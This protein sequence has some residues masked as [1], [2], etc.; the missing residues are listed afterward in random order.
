M[1]PTQ[2]R[3]II[4]ISALSYA[5]DNDRFSEV[6][7]RAQ[8]L[9]IGQPDHA[10]NWRLLGAALLKLGEAT[11]AV[12]ALNR[13]LQVDRLD[14]PT[15]GIRGVALQGLGFITAG[16]QSYA[17]ALVIDPQDADDLQAFFRPRVIG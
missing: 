7:W 17:T 2:S 6:V 9:A 5:F 14:Q 1:L 16:L 15:W 10:L 3:N 8:R 4:D 12:A 13:S 11:Q